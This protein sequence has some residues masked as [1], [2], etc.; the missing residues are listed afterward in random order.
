MSPKFR[1]QLWHLRY[2]LSVPVSVRWRCHQKTIQ[3]PW[4][5]WVTNWSYVHISHWPLE[6]REEGQESCHWGSLASY[7]QS[8][9][10][11]KGSPQ[12]HL[13]QSL[14]HRGRAFRQIMT[15]FRGIFT[16]W[17]RS[18]PVLSSWVTPASLGSFPHLRPCAL[19]KKV[20]GSTWTSLLFLLQP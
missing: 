10:L 7:Q 2:L 9:L 5:T 18:H 8:P 6:T 3:Y 4:D 12:R 14:L 15:M 16:L 11:R 1:H 17:S 13:P 19:S 20:L